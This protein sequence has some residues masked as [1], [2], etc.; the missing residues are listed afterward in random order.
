MNMSKLIFSHGFTT[1]SIVEYFVIVT[2]GRLVPNKKTTNKISFR[3]TGCLT[4]REDHP[5]DDVT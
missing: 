4:V 1:R 5:N 3:I 2:V